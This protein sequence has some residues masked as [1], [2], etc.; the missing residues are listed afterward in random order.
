ML[1]KHCLESVVWITHIQF[2]HSESLFAKI[3]FDHRQFQKWTTTTT[4]KKSHNNFS[5][6]LSFS[7]S[8]SSFTQPYWKYTDCVYTSEYSIILYYTIVCK[9]YIVKLRKVIGSGIWNRQYFWYIVFHIH[10]YIHTLT[11]HTV[12]MHTHI[13]SPLTPSCYFR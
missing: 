2:Q 10:S 3:N 11:M 9:L 4:T 12:P 13:S 1:T 5:T 7:I 8:F 6:S